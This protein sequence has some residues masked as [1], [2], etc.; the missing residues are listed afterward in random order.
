MNEQERDWD[1]LIIV[2]AVAFSLRTGAIS[3]ILQSEW[4]VFSYV[5]WLTYEHYGVLQVV[6]CMATRKPAWNHVLGAGGN[7]LF[8]PVQP[9]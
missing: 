2:K 9:L 5:R 8:Y 3:D 6:R 1:D 4:R 7:G